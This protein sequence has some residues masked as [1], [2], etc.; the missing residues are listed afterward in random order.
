MQNL[1]GRFHPK[2]RAVGFIAKSGRSV[3]PQNL[4]ALFDLKIWALC[5]IL[6]QIEKNTAYPKL[7]AL[8]F[9]TKSGRFVLVSNKWTSSWNFIFW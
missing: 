5:S 7:W 8:G 9:I 6:E 4:G 2:I 3:L 1:G